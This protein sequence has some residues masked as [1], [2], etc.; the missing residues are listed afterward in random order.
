VSYDPVSLLGMHVEKHKLFYENGVLDPVVHHRLVENAPEYARIAGIRVADIYEPFSG[1]CNTN[2]E[3]EFTSI[4][5][6][7]TSTKIAGM[8]YTEDM[9]PPIVDRMR[10]IT[11]TMLRNFEPARLITQGRLFDLIMDNSEL[12]DF[13]VICLPDLMHATT[14]I[15]EGLRRSVSTMFVDRYIEGLQIVLGKI[16][17]LKKIGERFG[18]DVLEII[19]LHY[20]PVGAANVG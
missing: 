20:I 8:Y 18:S 12:S 5:A 16:G 1:V 14:S 15:S 13:R 3:K 2:R 6:R 17:P 9:D 11:G 19:D 10:V 7:N 4:I